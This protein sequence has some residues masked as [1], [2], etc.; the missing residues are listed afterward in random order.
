MPINSRSLLFNDYDQPRRR[1]IFEGQTKVIY[2]GPEPETHVLYFK[3]NISLEEK[4]STIPGKGVLN[5]RVSSLLMLRLSDLGIDTHFIRTLNMRE[6][7]VR[8]TEAFPFSLTFHNV[9]FGSFAKRLGL[10]EGGVLT[11]PIPEFFLRSQELGNPVVAV[12]HLT[13]LGW[14][15][16][17]EIDDILL[18][19]QRIND[20]LSGQFL[21]LNLRLTSVTLEF[22]RFYRDDTSDPQIM[23][24]DELSCDTC[25]FLDLKTGQHLGR[26][27]IYS[28]LEQAQEIYQEVAHRLNIPGFCK[29]LSNKTLTQGKNS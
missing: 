28:N 23:L 21:A 14:G 27:G 2:D 25:D 16:F 12:E 1:Q 22:G 4:E 6:Q 19:A 17:E 3:D 9:A 11:K 7:L 5:N 10:E 15:R 8:K 13:V 29:K 20:F 24:T 26:Q 18:S